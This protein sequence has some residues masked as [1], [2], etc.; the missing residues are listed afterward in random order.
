M[1]SSLIRLF[2]YLFITAAPSLALSLIAMKLDIF[3]LI[4]F[5]NKL[6]W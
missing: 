2:A 1:N 5:Y 4:G 6:I 3:S